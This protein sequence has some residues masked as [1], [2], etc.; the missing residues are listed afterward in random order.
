[1]KALTS[2]T[3]LGLVL[4]AG[5]ALAQTTSDPT[6]TGGTGGGVVINETNDGAFSRMSPGNQKITD[7]LFNAQKAGTTSATGTATDIG[8]QAL[9]RDDIAA[10]KQDGQGFG[11]VF[12]DMKSEGLIDA[13]NLG[14][15]VSGKAVTTPTTPSDAG[16]V[17]T[18]TGETATA[19]ATSSRVTPTRKNNTVVTLGDGS[20]ATAATSRSHQGGSKTR[21]TQ[22]ASAQTTHGGSKHAAG[23]T[24]AGGSSSAARASGK[25][26]TTNAGGNVHAGVTTAAGSATGAGAQSGKVHGGGNGRGGK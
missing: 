16:D 8:T 4:A 18:G 26:H 12:K 23:V 3:A 6:Q 25:S 13:K 10:M 11:N 7:A 22:A 2:L 15:V 1:M 9:S 17:T 14:Q 24:T 19:S 5:T 20:T 21:G